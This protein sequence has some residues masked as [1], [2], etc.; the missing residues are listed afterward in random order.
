MICG[1]LSSG[2]QNAKK[3]VLGGDK[4]KNAV[5]LVLQIDMLGQATSIEIDADMIEIIDNG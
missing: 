5:R 4:M 3:G 1:A 2:S